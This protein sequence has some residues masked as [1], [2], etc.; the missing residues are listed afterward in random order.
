MASMELITW[1]LD[2]DRSR[3]ATYQKQRRGK[4]RK[5]DEKTPPPSHQLCQRPVST[6]LSCSTRGHGDSRRG[7][8]GRG[9][10][11]GPLGRDRG[12]GLQGRRGSGRAVLL[13][14]GCGQGVGAYG[15]GAPGGLGGEVTL[16]ENGQL[17]EVVVE[18]ILRGPA[19]GEDLV[20]VKDGRVAPPH[21]GR[22]AIG[23]GGGPG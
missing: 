12:G 19:K 11:G 23:L 13:G 7:N 8:G 16:L 15:P 5:R 17:P 4:Q 3:R 6:H 20:V 14:H 18:I 1:F 22:V 9:G 10:V 21:A 2:E